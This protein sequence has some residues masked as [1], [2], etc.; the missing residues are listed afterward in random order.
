M[1]QILKQS[2]Q[3]EGTSLTTAFAWLC[4]AGV[5]LGTVVCGFGGALLVAVAL[6]EDDL[7]HGLSDSWSV[8]RGKDMVK[9]PLT[10]ANHRQHEK[11]LPRTL[12]KPSEQLW[13]FYHSEQAMSF[14]LP[15]PFFSFQWP[16][17]FFLTLLAT[18]VQY[19]EKQRQNH[20]FS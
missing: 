20:I 1:W 15:L 16:T 5:V 6:R 7:P 19:N 9:E 17:F 3:E 8:K 10:A 18:A 13:D 2:G 11:L 12:S 4:C 14:R